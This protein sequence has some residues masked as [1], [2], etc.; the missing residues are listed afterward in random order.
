[1]L[2]SAPFFLPYSRAV[3]VNGGPGRLVGDPSLPSG[4]AGFTVAGGRIVRIDVIANPEKLQGVALDIVD[5]AD[6]VDY[7]DFS[8]I[9]HEAPTGDDGPRRLDDTDG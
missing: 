9:P 8:R 6:P 2:T 3:V 5:E 4:I 1:M 7:P